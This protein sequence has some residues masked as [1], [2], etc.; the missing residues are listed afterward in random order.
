VDFAMVAP[1]ITSALMYSGPGSEP[2]LA[3]A[4]AWDA[5]ADELHSAAGSY[6]SVVSGLT[7]GPWLGASSASMAAA[8][9]PY[10]AWLSVAAAQAEQ[11]AT[12]ARMAA[13]AYEAA[14]AATVPP[15]LI[16]ANRSLLT[17]LVATN[18]FGQNAPAIAATE[19]QYVQMWAQD[20]AVMYGYAG[21]SAAAAT[22]TPFSPPPPGANPGGLAAQ[23][24]ATAEATTTSAAANA[25]PAL[26][27]LISAMP[28]A[29]KM[30]STP[31]E[32][33]P[34]AVP[35]AGGVPG[36]L[37]VLGVL[38]VTP[39]GTPLG[40]VGTGITSAAWASA[41]LASTTGQDTRLRIVDVGDQILS[42][43]DDFE[44]RAMGPAGVSSGGG[45][46]VSAGLGQ[47]PLLGGLSVPQTWATTAP[48]VKTVAAALSAT[49]LGAGSA[50]LA[51][52]QG[53]LWS[54][55]ALASVAGRAV[56]AARSTG[57]SPGAQSSVAT[58]GSP[59]TEM[60]LLS[61]IERAL[62]GTTSSGRPAVMGRPP[63]AG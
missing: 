30:L 14:F 11:T 63:A 36:L 59:L 47:A 39:L 21:A 56:G 23:A 60:A 62:G 49:G 17:T 7:D 20:A 2:M 26:S 43:I 53:S 38:G 15:P 31:L 16:A 3:A 9:A 13:A 29:L 57:P 6:R 27:Q 4:V 51:A 35:A 8:A 41:S 28:T 10:I 1:E 18:L 25:E 61:L 52:G 40:G 12:R 22:L 33:V 5:L 48:A 34:S 50:G 37:D 42:R 24:A 45:R 46:A 44:T 32:S 58:P 55:I 19:S 54:E